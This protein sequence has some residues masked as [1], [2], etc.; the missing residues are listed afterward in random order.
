MEQNAK[1]KIS[2]GGFMLGEGLVLSEDGKTLSVSGGGGGSGSGQ[3]IVTVYATNA[4]G[5]KFAADKMYDEIKAAIDSGAMV[6]VHYKSREN[7]T[8]YKVFYN[9]SV[10][11][12]YYVFTCVNPQLDDYIYFYTIGI[13]EENG[14]MSIVKN[15][16]KV[17]S[18]NQA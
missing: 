17:Q 14:E 4:Q 18:V 1:K 16:Y 7:A 2:C 15:N 13:Y 3:F 12:G 11:G 10:E 5:T 8:D 6:L 9:T